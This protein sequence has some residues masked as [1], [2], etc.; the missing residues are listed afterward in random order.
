MLRPILLAFLF[1]AALAGPASAQERVTL[2]VGRLFTN[3]ALGDMQDRWH[4][5][6]YVASWMR[7]VDGT[8]SL[9]EGFG[10]LVEFRFAS[11]ILAPEDMTAPAA[12]D[13]RYAGTM[14]LGVYSHFTHAGFAFAT[15]AE[16]VAVGP[17][18]GL[19]GFHSAVHRE[20]GMTI[21]SGG[22]R[23]AQIG[24]ALYPVL[25]FEAA[26]PVRLGF[27]REGER[28]LVVRPFLQ[29][30]A[31]DETYAR[32]GADLMFGPN[33]TTGVLARDETTGML[34]QTF[35][36]VPGRGVS[37]ILG[38]DTARVLSSA[39]LPASGGHTLTTLRNRV[40]AGVH[41]QGETIGAFYGAT[42]LGPE[43]T[44]QTEGQVVGSMQLRLRF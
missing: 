6:S 9:P 42:W 2:G 5:G 33:F 32:I 36:D 14:S 24:N 18:T 26:R 12:G 22:V 30:R 16:L 3:D 39:W 1:I 44:A 28:G 27:G 29:A 35:D 23:A 38:A 17:M 4:T 11:Q 31:G 21:P 7:G 43:F 37:F 40:R 41:L 13:R 15:G 19:D 25:A 34:Y 8:V 20:L 10:E